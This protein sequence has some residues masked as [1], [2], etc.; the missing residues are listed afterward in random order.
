MSMSLAVIYCEA[1]E[2]YGISFSYYANDK[3]GNDTTLHSTAWL[4]P[5]QLAE[6]KIK[7]AEA[8]KE[9]KHGAV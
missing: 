6:L 2:Q 1:T 5:L 9:E 3:E 8:E 4:T 7:I